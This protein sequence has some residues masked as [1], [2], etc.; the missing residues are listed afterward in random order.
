MA[1]RKKL[2]KKFGSLRQILSREKTMLER[3]QSIAHLLT[4]NILSSVIGLIGF[5][6]TARALGPAGYGVLALCFSYARA[7]E[8]IV[9]FQSWQPLIK[10]GAHSLAES[11]GDATELRALLKFGLLLDISA[12]LVAWLIAVLLIL[13]AAPWLG[14]SGDGADLAILYCTVLPF[15]VSGMPTAVLRLYGRFMAIAYGQVATS[16]L[17]VVLCAIGVATGAGLFEFTLIWMSA[18]IIGTLSLVLFS[19]VELRRQGVLSGLMSAPLR[20]IT[21]RFP[22]LWKFAISANLSLT[23]RSSANELDTLLV[24]YLA[25]PTSAGLY[26]IAKRIGRIAQ[27][28]GVQVQAVLYPELARAWATKAF[29]AF[30]RAVA[31]MQGLLLGFGLLLI[32]GLYLLIGPLLTWAAGPDFAA[33]GPLVIVQSVAVTMTLCGAV[34][35]SALLA[36]GRENEILRSVT[37][38]AIGFHATAFALIPVIGAMGANVAHIVMASIWLSTMMLSYRRTPA[39]ET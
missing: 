5:A 39:P 22:G 2:L 36:M 37:I 7:V 29:S 23:I 8:R 30:H 27:Q 6:L 17:R 31:Q 11:A 1:F 12:A 13:V 20:G 35:R 16:V 3:L 38:A 26:H 32:G 4:G 15:Q 14:I 34:I 28:A 21:K 24:G 18:Q 9:S 33:A 10:Y 25:D 19:L